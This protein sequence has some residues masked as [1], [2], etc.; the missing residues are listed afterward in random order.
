MNSTR[1]RDTAAIDI[2]VLIRA[3]DQIEVF[4]G[5]RPDGQR[6]ACV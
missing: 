5:G 4:A 2:D 1:R 6:A 3:A